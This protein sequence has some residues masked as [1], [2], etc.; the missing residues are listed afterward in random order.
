MTQT[1]RNHLYLVDGSSY[2]FRAYHKLPPMTRADGTPV[3]A[4]YGFTTMLMK[5]VQDLNDGVAP[6]HLAVIFDAA[7]HSFRNDLYDQYK[8]NRP[9]PPEDLVPQFPLIREAVRAMS[10]PCIELQGWE[11]D[12]II[13][14]YTTQARGLGFDVTI[15][16]SDKDLMQ[17]VDDHV[18]L[19]DTMKNVRMGADA[20]QDKFG[21]G[22]DKVVDVQALAGDS[23]DNVPG[24]PGI[25]VKTAAQLIH[26]HGDLETLL[27]NAEGIKQ[28]KRRENLI[29]FADQARLSKKLVQLAC[30]VP[31]D[32][33]L[34]ALAVHAPDP[35]KLL[36]F[37]DANQ[38]KSLRA[39]VIAAGG[40]DDADDAGAQTGDAAEYT[41]QTDY[42]CV[43]D[44]AALDRWIAEAR[45]AGTVAVDTETTGL[46][47]MTARLV[48]V[49]LSV[50][51]GR[52]CYIPLAHRA[53]E[54]LALDGDGPAQIDKASALA[55][56]KPLLED[57]AVLK[58][59]QNIKYDLQILAHE[60]IAVSPF[61]DTM[62]ES[63]V[64][65]CGRHGH[66]M[67]ELAK[68]HLSVTPTPYK[69]VA[70]IGK[71]QV[72]FDL[73][74]LDKATHYAAEDADITGRLHRLLKPQLPKAG[75]LTVYETLERGMPA[76][77]Q[78]MERHGIKVDR[79]ALSRL[80]GDFAQRMGALEAE[81]HELAGETFNIA[82]PKQLGAILFDKMGL[83]GGKKGKTGAYSTSADV[84][85]K[86]AAEGHDLPARVLD[87][88]QLS[89]LKSTYTDALQ[90]DIHPETGRVHTSFSLAGTTTGRLASTD[91]NLQ[92][93]PVRTEEGREI[94]KAFV[95]EPGHRLVAADYSQ[96]EL[97]VLAHMAGVDALVEAFRDGQDIHAIT[98]SQVFDVPVDGMDPM[99]RR[100]A[101]A[102]N[103]GIIYGISGFGLA[104]QL[105]IPRADAQ[106][107]IDAYFERFPQIQDYM[108][109]TKAQAREQG[110][111]ETLFGRRTHTPA[112]KSKNWQERSF[113]ERAA[114]NAPIQGTAADIIRRA[115]LRMEAA[116]SDAGLDD[117]KMLLQVHDELI[118]EIAED[119][120]DRA[121]PVIRETMET[122]CAPVLDLAVPLVV[123]CGS[124][125]SWYEA[126]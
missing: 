84:L 57:P 32:D 97:R 86:L 24:V 29:A 83:Q 103:F 15:V 85:E 23:V 101:K 25:G 8:A 124:G 64:L 51:A 78:R 117:V 65:D 119:R 56:L 68:L 59:G 33:A 21:V 99:V 66:G 92:N 41:D 12:D 6:T 102:I 88:R 37:V 17:L 79:Q 114:I 35:H 26:D 111:V 39:K 81:I 109:R 9:E 49:S 28:K 61:D 126:H 69:A 96:I 116:L 54:G 19:F 120:V 62:L 80:S 70:G 73:V 77:L 31:L 38:F 93:I 105:G 104:N 14:T 40:L 43:T 53:S 123:D 115:M 107:Y 91:P 1:A 72:T 47:A 118:F 22:P 95:A 48:G 16:S 94:R 13:A 3:N 42:E 106:R 100:Q 121:I 75:L 52:A 89:K 76:V 108:E 74:P 82:S 122:A 30:D 71:K 2:I 110:Y 34:D 63:Y 125:Q 4:V 45:E 27:A 50:V 46:N 98:A 55:A 113:A 67:D 18:Q 10:L 5:L 58:V 60:G 112:I 20:V 90:D 44:M 11:A 87:W 36:A 7:K